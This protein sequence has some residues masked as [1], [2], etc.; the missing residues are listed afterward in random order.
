MTSLTVRNPTKAKTVGSTGQVCKWCLWPVD[1]SYVHH[2]GGFFIH[3]F[4]FLAH[5]VCFLSFHP[6]LVVDEEKRVASVSRL[7]L[8]P[9]R[10]GARIK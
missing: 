4:W 5:H 7:V 3:G 8:V 2:E 1:T 10:I 6:P 9:R